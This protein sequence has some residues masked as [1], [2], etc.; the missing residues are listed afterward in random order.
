MAYRKGSGDSFMSMNRKSGVSS[1]G[2]QLTFS[3]IVY[4]AFTALLGVD[5][6]AGGKVPEALRA[7]VKTDSEA[8]GKQLD[9]PVNLSDPAKS[10]TLIGTLKA[11]ASVFLGYNNKFD[12]LSTQLSAIQAQIVSAES[13]ITAIKAELIIANAQ[14]ATLNTTATAIDSGV[15]AVITEV[16]DLGV[17]A[18]SIRTRM[19]S[20]FTTI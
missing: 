7:T 1:V 2:S 17:T 20:P 13:E 16:Q 6:V 3:E 5:A 9:S 18:T 10:W 14:L 12:A 4:A 8:I 19:D 11:F 15:S